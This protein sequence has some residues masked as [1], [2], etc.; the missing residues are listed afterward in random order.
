M[1]HRL[2]AVV[3]ADVVGYGHLIREDEAGTRERLQRLEQELIEPAVAVHEGRIIKPIA[4]GLLAEFI[5]TLEALR[6]AVAIQRALAR[7][8]ASAGRTAPLQLRVG[9]NLGDVH[10]EGGEIRGVGVDIAAR[11]EDLVEPGGV[12]ITSTVLAQVRG[13]ADVAFED[14]GTIEIA[15]VP[16]PVHVFRVLLDPKAAAAKTTDADGK[17]WSR[18][19]PAVILALAAVAFLLSAGLWLFAHNPASA[20]VAPETFGPPPP[21]TR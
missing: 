13:R 10:A 4:D 20:P 21:E 15:N 7:P 17:R 8:D 11:M 12:C 5:S 6:C 9:V 3:S 18:Q 19:W 16:Q 1:H 2:A 14:L